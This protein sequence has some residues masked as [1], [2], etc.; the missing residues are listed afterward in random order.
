MGKRFF[1]ALQYPA[2]CCCRAVNGLDWIF[3]ALAS[4]VLMNSAIMADSLAFREPLSVN[5]GYLDRKVCGFL[6]SR[7]IA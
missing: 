7:S 2:N 6:E 1:R 4:S 3:G 5:I